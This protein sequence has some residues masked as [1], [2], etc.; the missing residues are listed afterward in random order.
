MDYKVLSIK[1]KAR[2]VDALVFHLSEIDIDS[3]EIVDNQILDSDLEETFSYLSDIESKVEEGYS[4]V[5]CYFEPETEVKDYVQ[6]VND[7]IKELESFFEIGQY[8]IT[9]DE[10]EDDYLNNW[11]Q[12]YKVIEIVNLAIVPEWEEYSGT[13]EMIKIEP[14]YAFGSGSHETTLICL[15]LMQKMGL[16]GKSVV[17]VGCGSGILSI[18]AHK[19]GAKNI[20]AI[21]ID[22]LAIKSSTHNFELN[23][24]SDKIKLVLGNLLDNVDDGFDVIVSN[25]V[26]NVLKNMKEDLKKR[27]NKGGIIIL[28]GILESQSEDLIKEFGEDFTIIERKFMGE[29]QGAVLRYE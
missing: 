29:W 16:K 27:L 26:I 9:S 17:D 15:E 19:L 22:E 18:A 28:S 10:V 21:D 7:I 24:V 14:A 11:K 5:K 2:A 6:K 3:V 23:N 13:K 25:I 12:Y 4:I 1:I 20:T 8:S